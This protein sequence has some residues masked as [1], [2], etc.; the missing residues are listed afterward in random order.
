M[1]MMIF[2]LVK[3]IIKGVKGFV[4][5]D[6]LLHF[7]VCAV[8]VF[9]FYP[10]LDN[11]GNAVIVATVVGLAKEYM[12]VLITRICSWKHAL[13]DILFDALGVVY[14]V[15][16]IS[17]C[18]LWAIQLWV[19]EERRSVWNRIEIREWRYEWLK[20]DVKAGEIPL[21]FIKIFLGVNQVVR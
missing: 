8:I 3:K 10:I 13:K 14:A 4:Q 6:G 16:L 19:K 5:L 12:D 1:M 9:T 2:D 18:G 20:K 11:I 17:G 7:L 21:F 15:V